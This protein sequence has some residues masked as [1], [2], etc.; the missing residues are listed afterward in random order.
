MFKDKFIIGTIVVTLVIIIAGLFFMTKKSAP[1]DVGL[2]VASD[3]WNQGNKD[4]TVTLVEYLDFECE[5]CG[6]YYPLIK[7][8]KKEFE[9]EVLFINRYFPLPGHRNALQASYAAEAAGKQGKYWE[10]HDALFENQKVWGGK[11]SADPSLFEVYAK[12]IGLDIEKFKTDVKSE[13]VRERVNRD[14]RSGADL[15]VT[16]TPTFYLNGVKLQNPRS[17]EDFRT[18][19]KAAIL[20]SPKV[21]LGEKVHE[22][23]D[24]KVFINGKAID[25][26]NDKYQ[27]TT[28][29]PLDPDTHLHDGVGT[30]MHKH[31]K[32]V[33]LGYFF[34]TL[35]MK[36]DNNCF[37]T[38][39]G[40]T[41]CN[42]ET[43]SLRLYVNGVLNDKYGDYEFSD[44]DKV[45]ITYGP[46]NENVQSQTNSLTDMACMYSEKC[47]ER[48]KP[49]TESC[50]GGLGTDC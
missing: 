47:P 34:E 24:F 45:L 20:N 26:T 12:E 22:H 3:D 40:K 42:S 36:F 10:M 16:G 37:N 35:G 21:V 41:H 49:P 1:S 23:A 31:R 19:I 15:Q 4:A 33:T 48:G 17:L 25:F 2:Q 14:L 9:T 6:T 11:Q 5:V 7:E 8:L 29:N 38:D 30:I 39:D 13:E 44:L 27:S 46:K 50:V 18:Q 32:G 43:N 28:D